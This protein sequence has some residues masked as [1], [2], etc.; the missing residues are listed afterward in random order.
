MDFRVEDA[1]IIAAG[2]GTRMLPASLYYPKEMLPL[3]D[4]PGIHHLIA[5]ARKAGAKRIH[6]V[7][8]EEKISSFREIGLKGRQKI[9]D[10]I[11]A[12]LP[13]HQLDPVTED[14]E[15][16]IHIQKSP[17][18]VGDAILCA[19]GDIHGPS[20]VIMGDNILLPR[21]GLSV[22]SKSFDGSEASLELVNRYKIS[23]KPVAG[24]F[25]VNMS[26]IH[27]YGIVDIANGMVEGITEKPNRDQVL[28]NLALCGRFIFP[29]GVK[30]ILEMAEISGMGELQSIGLLNYLIE[31]VGLEV[32]EFEDYSFLDSGE[33]VSW[34]KAQIEHAIFREDLR[35]EIIPW[36]EEVLVKAKD[37]LD[38]LG[39]NSELFGNN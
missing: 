11:R 18:G 5:E 16:K 24:V 21:K 36:I 7:V 22:L 6:L 15:L 4:S 31:N 20:I 38:D 34:L 17:K 23:G 39:D 12:D 14:A 8:S 25:A 1:I 10:G 29:Q 32:Y 33:P 19:L 2:L 37:G 26:E 13:D 27:N 3:V 30:E 35:N 28:S 9:V